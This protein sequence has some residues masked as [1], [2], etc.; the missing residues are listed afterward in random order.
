MYITDYVCDGCGYSY[1]GCGGFDFTPTE[2]AQTISCK[3]CEELRDMPLGYELFFKYA[4][5]SGMPRGPEQD[6]ALADLLGTLTFSCDVEPWHTVRPWA[7][8]RNEKVP[9]A[10]IDACPRCG[11]HMSQ[12]EGGMIIE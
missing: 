12:R 3:Q 2:G 1:T 6:R 10:I 11:A 4:V 7:Y 8:A 5:T 9:G